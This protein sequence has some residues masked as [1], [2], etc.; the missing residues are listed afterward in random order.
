MRQR[1]SW[2]FAVL[3]A[4]ALL[5]GGQTCM[6]TLCA[7]R[8]ARAQDSAHACCAAARAAKAGTPAPSA[9]PSAAHM[10]CALRIDAAHAPTLEAPAQVAVEYLVAAPSAHAPLRI[11]GVPPTDTGPPPGAHTPAPAGLRAPPVA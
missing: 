2:R 1:P 4:L 11:E 10:P 6:M 8:L 9:D 7:P 3:A 5:V